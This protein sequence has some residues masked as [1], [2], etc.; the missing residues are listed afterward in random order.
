MVFI[1][2]IGFHYDPDIFPD[3]EKFDP[4]RFSPEE[5]SKRDPLAYM[6]FGEGPRI[7]IGKYNP[8]RLRGLR[9]MVL[10]FFL[11][12]RFGLLQTKLGLISILMKYNV[13]V[14]KETPIPIVYDKRAFILTPNKGMPLKLS[15]R[16]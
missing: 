7:C 1:P 14:A 11:G 6:P 15:S 3:P 10:F 2:A 16:K 12:S 13:E 9:K 5:K 4:T 8:K